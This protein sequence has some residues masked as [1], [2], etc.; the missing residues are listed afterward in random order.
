MIK[1]KDTY[2]SMQ[3]TSFPALFTGHVQFSFRGFQQTNHRIFNFDL[4]SQVQLRYHD[5]VLKS[6]LCQLT[7]QNNYVLFN[8]C[9]V[10]P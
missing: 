1:K 4:Y 6:R 7:F 10:Y 3:T 9:L 5:L 2:R 8:C